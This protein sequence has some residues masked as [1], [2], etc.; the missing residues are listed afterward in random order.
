MAN[1]YKLRSRKQT[2]IKQVA[3]SKKQ[4]NSKQIAPINKTKSL[5]INPSAITHRTSLGPIQTSGIHRSSIATSGLTTDSKS[6]QVNNRKSTISVS[7]RT[8][9]TGT[10]SLSDK[11]NSIESRIKSVEDNIIQESRLSTIESA[12]SQIKTDNIELQLTVE[13]LKLDIEGLQFVIAHLCDSESKFK[14]TEDRLNAENENLKASLLNLSSEVE[15][16]RTTASSTNDGISLEQQEVNSN[17]IIRGVELNKDAT[18]SDLIAVYQKICA[19]LGATGTP[20]LEPVE[21]SILTSNQKAKGTDSKPI[22]IKLRSTAAKRQFLQIRRIKR[23]ILPT[24]IGIVQSSKKALLITEELTRKNQ[25][26]LYKARSLRSRDQYRFVWSNNGQILARRSQN[27]KVVRIVDNT[28]VESLRSGLQPLHHQLDQLHV[29][30][31]TSNGLH[32]SSQ[33]GRSS[34]S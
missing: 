17:I 30:P 14:E 2:D 15:K 23:D 25:E 24:D 1:D 6:A 33:S 18:E 31:T 16:L 5:P 34:Q 8:P 32:N 11:I 7:S 12:F 28:H 26:L 4:T 20:D 27:S 29:P 9:A 22:R 3:P 19:H 10:I 13:R 21:A